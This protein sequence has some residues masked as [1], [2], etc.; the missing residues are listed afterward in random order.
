MET[1]EVFAGSFT[2]NPTMLAM[3]RDTTRKNASSAK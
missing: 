2:A 3:L 1:I